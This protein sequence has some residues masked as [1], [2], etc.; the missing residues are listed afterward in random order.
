MSTIGKVSPVMIGLCIALSVLAL[1]VYAVVLS[2]LG[3]LAAS[4]AAGNAYAQAYAAIGLVVLWLLLFIIVAIALVKGAAGWPVVTAAVVLLLA[5]GIVS[6]VA[7]GLLASPRQPPYLWPIVIP[8]G[9]PPLV[10]AFSF[11]LLLPGLRD[12]LPALAVVPA[13][14]GLVF[15]LSAAIVPLAQMRE[16]YKESIAAAR[17]RTEAAYADLSP[18]AALAELLPFMGAFYGDREIELNKRIRALPARQRDVEEML[19]RGDF[20]L[21]YLNQLELD[22]TPSL[23]DKARA[24]LRQQAAALVLKPGDSKPYA[25]IAQPM[26]DAVSAMKWLV[27]HDCSCD[28]ESLAWEQMA[29]AYAGTS[30]DIF[31][32]KRLRDPQELGRILREYPEKF[33][34][35]TPKASLSAWLNFAEEEE[36]RERAVAGARRLPHRNA[37]IVAMLNNRSDEHMAWMAMTY[38]PELDLEATPELCRAALAQIDLTFSKVYRPKP[39]D[40]RSY[41]ELLDRLGDRGR[42]RAALIWLGERGCDA[43]STITNAEELVR[44]YQPSPEREAMLDALSRLPRAK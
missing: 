4:D 41:D 6:M 34:M 10:I 29:S 25:V 8:A 37:E 33:S 24:Q 2:L 11:W 5:S 13:V 36:Y 18:N 16:S 7:M 32:L 14:W 26:S 40:P 44:A 35:L 27:G 28:A 43:G 42:H 21:R 31:E 9:V 12:A 39:D 19:A 3:G 20:P 17:A 38:L 1:I 22:P 15:V 23:C 30:Y